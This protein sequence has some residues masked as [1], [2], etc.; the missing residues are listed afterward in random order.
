M[1][2]LSNH[3]AMLLGLNEAWQ[4][5]DVELSLEE[6][7]VEIHLEATGKPVCC[8]ECGEQRSLKDHAPERSWRHLD[9]MQFETVLIA[10][11][12]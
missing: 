3:Y 7:R 5:Q 9:T 4:V 12:T 1:N 2:T 8:S 6:Q 11:V 10:K